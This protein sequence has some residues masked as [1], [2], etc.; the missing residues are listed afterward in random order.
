MKQKT[1]NL[2]RASVMIALSS[3]LSFFKIIELAKGG[4][5]TLGSMVPVILI[6]FIIDAKWGIFSA[7]CYSLVQMLIGGIAAPPTQNFIYYFL[8]I[9][10]DYVVAFTVLGLGST[11]SSFVK[12]K[13]AKLISGTFIVVFLRFVCHFLSGILIWDVY[14]PEGQNVFLYSLI[15]NGSYMGIELIV[16]LAVVT[17]ISKITYIKDLIK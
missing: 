14:A 13:T 6:S 4:S 2:T 10:L 9:M 11:L 7:F 8:V 15:Y 17:V 5:V 16:T 1:F 12:N 3:A